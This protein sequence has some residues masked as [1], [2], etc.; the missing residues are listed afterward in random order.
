MEN[1]QMPNNQAP[2]EQ[3][4]TPNQP[5]KKN[6]GLIIGLIIGGIALLLALIGIVAVIVVFVIVGV[7]GK[8]SMDNESDYSYDFDDGTTTSYDDYDNDDEDYYDN[9][10]DNTYIADENQRIGNSTVGYI[11]A[12]SD[13]VVFNEVDGLE[14]LDGVQYSDAT[15][16]SIITMQAYEDI[17]AYD[18]ANNVYNHFASDSA[19][20]ESSLSSASVTIGGYDAYQVYCYYPDDH[21]Y[22]VTWCFNVSDVDSY[23]HY[24]AIEFDSDYSDLW[25]LGDTFDMSY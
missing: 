21:M 23:G 2:N 25:K 5:K 19:V 20:D 17:D 12:P 3:Q 8:A 22:V 1:N 6:T 10:D 15:G 24:I 4:V 9:D 18:M 16:T 14:G 13:F 11:D 7:G